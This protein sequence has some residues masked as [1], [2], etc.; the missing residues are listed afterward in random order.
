MASSTPSTRA[1]WKSAGPH[2]SWHV[3][4]RRSCASCSGCVRRRSPIPTYRALSPSSG[5]VGN[6]IAGIVL[7]YSRSFAIGDRVRIG[8]HLG[9]VVS[10]GYFATKLRSPR[11]E[12]ITLPNGQVA[13]QPIVNFT[14]L[15]GK[16]GLVLH[17][18]VT[19][20]YGAEWKTVHGLL[21]EAAGRVEGVER[22]PEPWV[23]QR[24][25][26]D[27]HITYEICC[28]TRESHQQLLLYSRLHEEIQDAFARAGVE[29]LSPAYSSLR[30]AN[31]PVLPDEPKGP[32][33]EPGGFRIRPR[34]A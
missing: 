9:D 29:I 33:A 28:V 16:A 10:L 22:E 8:E 19:I 32:R 5:P 11:N 30:D 7:T 14:R 3:P 1:P 24:S 4:R 21:I 20:G 31:A 13:A 26:N 15:A 6:V 2:R 25:L 18:Q 17:T 34:D 27:Y 23:F 12:E